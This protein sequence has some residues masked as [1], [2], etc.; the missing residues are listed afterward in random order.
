VNATLQVSLLAEEHR[1][2]SAADRI[3]AGTALFIILNGILT[4]IGWWDHI[5]IL[6][7]LRSDDAPTQF[8][9]AL[10]VVLLGVGELGMVTRHRRLVFTTA[11]IVIFLATVEW[12]QYALHIN[13]GLDTLFATPFVGLGAP[14]PGRMPGNTVACLLLI[15]GAQVLMS[16][17]HSEAGASTTAAVVMKTLAGG[18]AFVALLGYLADVKGA[19][20]WTDSAG[21]SLRSLAGFLLLVAARIAALWQ[22]DIIAKP[23]LPHWFLPFLTIAA[24]TISAGLIWVSTSVASA[25]VHDVDH[26]AGA[27]GLSAAIIVSVSALIVLGT[28]SVLVARHKATMALRQA[29][30]LSVQRT[31]VE[32]ELRANNKRLARS[33]RDLEDF[34]YV[35]SHDLRAPLSGI[36]SAAKWLT[37]DLQEGLSD[38]SK[39]LLGLMRNRI[40]RME[41]LLDDLLAYSR[42]GR[43]DTAINQTN[44]SDMFENIVAI[45][46][47]P[48]HIRVRVEGLLPV[49]VTASAQLEQVLRN[50]I[51][52]AIKHHDKASGEVVLSAKRVG[53]LIEFTVRDD[54]PGILP[55]FHDR[56]FVLFQTLKRRDEVEGSGMGLALV[57]KLVEQQNCSISVHSQGNGTGTE[58]SFQWPTT[59]VT[60]DAQEMT[61]A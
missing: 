28:M 48:A 53:D 22:R 60:S 37:Q 54:G 38:G 1:H 24:V 15:C 39:K 19:Y 4:C 49:I 20:G 59:A 30:D 21:M 58:F 25:L 27:G 8:I 34:A 57:K 50:L 11:G 23:A 17:P 52:N 14:H 6:V 36:D 5:P 12:A 3:V 55:Q 44:V 35:A 40:N 26:V 7:Q 31:E 45:L 47:P 13:T 51:N 42:A 56:I 16:K 18:I 33:N 41:K 32:R 46:N 9:S 43:T 10:S 61:N 29:A 2:L